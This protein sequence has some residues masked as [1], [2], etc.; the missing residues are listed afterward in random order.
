[1]LLVELPCEHGFCHLCFNEILEISKAKLSSA[2]VELINL[3]SFVC[4]KCQKTHYVGEEE[5]E[6][7]QAVSK[8]EA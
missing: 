7:L 4:P 3:Q 1:M 2:S 5:R 8:I 6:N